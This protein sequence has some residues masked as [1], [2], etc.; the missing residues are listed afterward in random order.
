MK[1]LLYCAICVVFVSSALAYS[2][3]DYLTACKL[4]LR[5]KT[6]DGFDADT[7]ETM[8]IGVCLGYTRGVS[9]AA[10]IW[11]LG[12]KVQTFCVPEEADA[13]QLVR[14]AVKYLEDNPAK[15]H[16]NAASTVLG[17]FME[18]FPCTEGEK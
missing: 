15:L 4:Y 14:V 2:S 17:A 10:Q 16:Y 8:Q 6:P 1:A 18:A 9:E 5:A 7:T 11:Q 12:T 3:S 13:D